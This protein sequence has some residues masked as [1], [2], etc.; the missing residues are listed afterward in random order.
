MLHL[1]NHLS[2]RRR[3]HFYLKRAIPRD[4]RHSGV[5]RW[6]PWRRSWWRSGWRPWWWWQIQLLWYLRA[7]WQRGHRS[8]GLFG[9]PKEDRRQR[10]G[11]LL[12]VHRWR[13]IPRW[14]W[15]ASLSCRGNAQCRKVGSR[16]GRQA[17]HRKGWRW[18]DRHSGWR[19][20]GG[21]RNAGRWRGHRR[22]GRGDPW[23]RER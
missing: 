21:T 11:R 13:R 19:Q 5:A 23:H 9:A 7:C 18:H 22:H 2:G 10:M 16:Q 14:W 12:C 6:R 1:L 3:R 15:E 20:C 4:A 17:S 8:A